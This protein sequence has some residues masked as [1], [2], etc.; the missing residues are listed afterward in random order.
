[1]ELLIKIKCVF[2]SSRWAGIGENRG[3]KKEKFLV[4][5][6]ILTRGNGRRVII[7]KYFRNL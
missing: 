6:N 5:Q 4:V 3:L 7:N 2:P 1:M